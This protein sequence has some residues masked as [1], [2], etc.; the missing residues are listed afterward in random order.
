M[1]DHDV[2]AGAS[3]GRLLP[4]RASNPPDTET[5]SK[6]SAKLQRHVSFNEFVHERIFSV[7]PATP[8]PEHSGN[9][10]ADSD[11]SP[12]SVSSDSDSI[13][14]GVT[15]QVADVADHPPTLSHQQPEGMS[16]TLYSKIRLPPPPSPPDSPPRQSAPTLPQHSAA[17]KSPLRRSGSGGS[18]SPAKITFESILTGISEG[19]AQTR[20]ASGEG[21][22][23]KELRLSH[24]RMAESL[25]ERLLSICER[26]RDINVLEACHPAG[27]VM[28]RDA[29]H[30]SRTHV[31]ILSGTTVV[32]EEVL[33]GTRDE[34]LAQK[35]RDSYRVFA[36]G[37]TNGTG[38]FD[39]HTQSRVALRS[40]RA[41]API[42]PTVPQS[43]QR[44]RCLLAMC[45]AHAR[46]RLR[47]FVRMH[48]HAWHAAAVVADAKVTAHTVFNRRFLRMRQLLQSI[49]LWRSHT[50]KQIS[51][52]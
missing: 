16:A 3:M 46:T 31:F 24:E 15:V 40:S 43:L 42:A 19:G 11:L 6:V 8:A 26:L 38:C 14:N 34:R 9:G 45:I 1:T 52:R 25:R 10:F 20:D 21:V 22:T 7:V 33:T 48:M 41:R 51:I 50:S 32:L 28:A 12:S 30:F 47:L 4:S 5:A 27:S 49:R 36:S 13:P 2:S 23:E 37:K 17:S 18:S 44:T 39:L 35:L 29:C